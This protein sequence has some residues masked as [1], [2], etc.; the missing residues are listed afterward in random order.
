MEK[1]CLN[2]MANKIFAVTY[3]QTLKE[4]FCPLRQE[5]RE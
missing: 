5:R 2:Y 4:V 3:Y 1:N